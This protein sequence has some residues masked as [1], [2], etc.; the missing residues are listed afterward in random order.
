MRTRHPAEGVA[1][2]RNTK[3]QCDWKLGDESRRPEAAFLARF[4][5]GTRDMGGIVCNEVRR[6]GCHHAEQTEKMAHGITP[7]GAW[8]RDFERLT[9]RISHLQ[10]WLVAPRRNGFISSEKHICHRIAVERPPTRIDQH[11]DQ[12]EINES[13]CHC[14]MHV[15]SLLVLRFTRVRY[16]ICLNELRRP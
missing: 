15:V 12:Q 1:R 10:G 4:R 7:M 2:P 11:G 14:G 9:S 5:E 16:L 13:A 8:H 6:Q 3:N